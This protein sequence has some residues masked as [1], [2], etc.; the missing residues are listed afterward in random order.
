MKNK[1]I[2]IISLLPIPLFLEGFNVGDAILLLISCL[3]ILALNKF[4]DDKGLGFEKIVNE[5]ADW[6]V[7]VLTK[8]KHAV[9]LERLKW[10]NDEEDRKIASLLFRGIDSGNSVY[11]KGAE[12]KAE[13]VAL[14]SAEEGRRFLVNYKGS[15]ETKMSILQAISFFI[16]IMLILFA[17][18]I[19]ESLYSQ[20]Y[21]SIDYCLA[22]LLLRRYL[23]R[24]I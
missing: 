1:I 3:L 22:I 5:L 21:I 24:E 17:A 14:L 2:F 23:L 20:L 9:L 18:N 7:G 10:K 11:L 8:S 4:R 19:F 6:S 15:L 13:E 16:P 12:Q